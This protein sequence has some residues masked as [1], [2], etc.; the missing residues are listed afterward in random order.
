MVQQAQKVLPYHVT[1][2]LTPKC[3]FNCK[4]CYIHETT[5]HSIDSS[6]LLPAELWIDAAKEARQLGA[7]LIGMTGGEVFTRSD[8]QH[9][10]ETIYD[11]GFLVNVLT[12]GYLITDKDIKWLSRRKPNLMKITLYGASD[13][14]YECVC[15][16]KH[17]FTR[18]TE[19][20]L[21]LKNAGIRLKITSTLIK[22][23]INDLVAMREWA[24]QHGFPFSASSSLFQPIRGATRDIEDIRLDVG[25]NGQLSDD[26]LAFL[27]TVPTS[28]F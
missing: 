11:M 18:V 12:N 10:Y 23:N 7:L 16:V 3:N 14:T 4:M 20:I 1:F 19:N 21:K 8:F 26:I 22:D 5:E 24:T 9:I 15:G 2:E 28:R 25:L 17:G 27:D 6:T 13:D